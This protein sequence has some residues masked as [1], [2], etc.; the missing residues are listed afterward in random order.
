VRWTGASIK[1]DATNTTGLTSRK[2][3]FAVIKL[4][5]LFL[6]ACLWSCFQAP[7][8][9]ACRYNVRETGFVD[10]DVERYYFYGYINK[11][12]PADIASGFSQISSAAFMDSNIK[13]EVISTDPQKDHPAL[14][15]L[16]SSQIKSFPAA[17]LVSPDG[18]SLAVSVTEPNRPF[19]DALQA[20]LNDILSSPKREEIL[21]H[22]IEA[23]CV[24]L[25]IEGSD[26]QKNQ[27]AKAAAYDAIKRIE[28][29]MGML[30]KPIAH[31][32]ALVVADSKSLRQEKVLLWSLGLDAQEVTEP[33]IAVIYGKAR[34]IGPLLKGQEIT[35]ANLANIL[36]VIGDDCEC[37]MD[38]RW[39]QGT[40]LPVKWDQKL[41]A[42]A[43][44]NLGFDPENPM[45]KMEISS[46]VG[47]GIGGSSYPSVPF[48]YQSDNDRQV[49]PVQVKDVAPPAATG[50]RPDVDN[51]PVADIYSPLRAAAMVA[52]G[53]SAVVV[54][55]GIVVLLRPKRI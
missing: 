2:T 10:L 52:I 7:L 45:I 23:Y 50:K 26:T 11:D 55:I 36:F 35:E 22:V 5:R 27:E 18:Q 53:L 34:W 29:Q 40:M 6:F 25:L 42:K 24:V 9:F 3:E 51:P 20:A 12:T 46:I 16:K 13:P 1:A 21:Q 47:R 49:A 15:Y 37:G 48:G 44:A 4:Q 8:A 43:A 14:E 28:A 41:Q 31:P 54:I 19:R 17:V 39:L 32:P 33:H 38:H 30:P